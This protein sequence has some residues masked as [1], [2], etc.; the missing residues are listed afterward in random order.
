MFR[1]EREILDE[2]NKFCENEI[3]TAIEI[4]TDKKF[5]TLLVF[6][7]GR[8]GIYNQ[9]INRLYGATM[10]ATQLGVNFDKIGELYYNFKDKL[11]ASI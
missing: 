1:T 10:F 2:Y 3:K 11:S 4:T 8:N 7:G 9:S 6:C 5:E